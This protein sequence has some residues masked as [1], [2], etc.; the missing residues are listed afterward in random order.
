MV[1]TKQKLNHPRDRSIFIDRAFL[2]NVAIHNVLENI[3]PVYLKIKSQDEEITVANSLGVES[4]QGL[5][6]LGFWKKAIY[7]MDFQNSLAFTSTFADFVNFKIVFLTGSKKYK[8]LAEEKLVHKDSPNFD[9]LPFETPTDKEDVKL[10][11]ISL[12]AVI[13]D[14][15]Q[16]FLLS[17]NKSVINTQRS[18]VIPEFPSLFVFNGVL[19]SYLEKRDEGTTK[20]MKDYLNDAIGNISKI[21]ANN[22]FKSEIIDLRIYDLVI[23]LME[24][25]LA[26]NKFTTLVDL[27]L[28]LEYSQFINLLLALE[29]LI[30]FGTSY[31]HLSKYAVVILRGILTPWRVRMVEESEVTNIFGKG[32]VFVHRT[33]LLVNDLVTVD[34]IPASNSCLLDLL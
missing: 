24:I 3:N 27:I 25:L 5:V 32:R 28:Q 6:V 20:L 33:S 30:T 21:F 26:V 23:F 16:K 1:A 34:V 7:I 8:H 29:R 10:S 19:W 9:I 22:E 14:L 2:A 4:Y 17:V 13:W 31:T 12:D 11:L 15:N 18:I